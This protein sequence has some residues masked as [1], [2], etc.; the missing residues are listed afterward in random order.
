ML[1]RWSSWGAIAD[2]FDPTRRQEWSRAREDLHRLLRD[3][4]WRAASRTTLNAHF[5]DAAF[6]KAMWRAAERLGFAGGT[7]LE[8]GCG[9]GNFLAF[10]PRS[11]HLIGVEWD[12]V[13]AAIAER[14]YPSA[15]VLHESF[16][17]TRIPGSSLDL[18]VGNVPFA[19][20]VLHDPQ[21]NPGKHSIHNHF[22]IKSVAGLR[23]GGLALLLT[24]RYTLDGTSGAARTELAGMADLIGVVRLP[25][26]AHSR[27]AGTDVIT[28]LVVLRRRESGAEPQGLPWLHARPTLLPDEHDPAVQEEIAI[29]EAFLSGDPRA[30]VI[31]ELRSGHGAYQ[32]GELVIPRP[33]DVEAGVD[34]ALERITRRAVAD[35]A[36]WT[37]RRPGDGPALARPVPR[38][39][40]PVEGLVCARGAGFTRIEDGVEVEF[41]VPRSQR[42]E[43][44]WLLAMRDRLIELLDLESRPQ[45]EDLVLDEKRASLNAAYDAYVAR[46]GP[47]NRFTWLRT[48][49]QDDDGQEILRKQLAARGRIHLDTY[50]WALA[51][52]EVFDPSTQL[53]QKA[54]ILHR[55]VVAP[56][57]VP[58]RAE[59]PRD[60]LA[61]V[62]D[63]KA[64]VDLGRIAQLL[65][66]PDDE[67]ARAALGTLVYQDP[68]TDRLAPAPAY[69]S[70]N[71]RRK[72]ER[73]REAERDEPGR[74]RANLEALERVLP[75]DL[76]PQ[77][78]DARLGATWISVPVVQRFVAELLRVPLR[79]V[80]I[81]HT[82]SIWSVDAPDWSVLAT[83]E[84]GTG[85]APTSRLVRDLLEQRTTMIRVP[86]R[87][88]GGIDVEETVAAQEAAR[89]VQERFREWIWEDPDRTRD[90]VAE[91]N[92][93]FNSTVLRSY[94]GAELALP[95]LA[96]NFEPREHQVAAVARMVAEPSVL[97]AHEVGAGK[98]AEMVMGAIELRRLHLVRKPCFVVPN[99]MVEQ[100]SREFLQLYPRARVLVGDETSAGPAQRRS[101]VGR[102]SSGDWDGVIMS[103][104]VFERIPVSAA[105]QRKFVEAEVQVLRD[106]LELA[107][108]N[109]AGRSIKRME[110][111]ILNAESRIERN[112]SG[113]HD[114]DGVS[115]ERTGIDYLCVDEAHA[116]KNLRIV[117]NLEGCGQVGSR[118]ADDLL[119]KLE[120]LRSVHGHRV[121]TFATATPISNAVSEAWVVQRFLQ[122]D[123]L[124]EAGVGEFDSWAA[125]FGETRTDIEL[126]PAG[127][128]YR[129]KTRFSKYRNVPE[130][131]LQLHQVADVKMPEDLALPKPQ[132]RGGKPEVVLVT[133][134]P[135]LEGFIQSLGDRADRMTHGIVPGNDN[136]LKVC[137]D[138][139]LGALDLRLVDLVDDPDAPSKVEV[140]ADRIAAIWSRYRDAAYPDPAGL[141]PSPRRGALQ[142]V[143]ADVGTPS[144]RWNPYD[145]LRAELVARGM[146]AAGIRFVHQARNDREK[147]EL[148]AACRNGEVSVLIGS[149]E[150]MGV[151]TNV[152]LRAIALHHLDCPW[153]P[154]DVEQREGRILRQGNC[155][156]EVE[157]I[158][159]AREGSFDV[160]M[161]Q[162][163]ERKGRFV[164]Q[165]MRGRL[166][167][168]EMEDPTAS[169]LSYAEV[170]ALAAGD[171]RL[172][173][174]ARLEG[175]VGRLS[176]LEHAWSS[177]QLLLRRSAERDEIEMARMREELVVLKEAV[178]RRTS[179]KGDAFAFFLRT[180]QGE[181]IMD[182]TAA[183]K[184]I[185][186]ALSAAWMTLRL[187]G[188]EAPIELGAVG[189]FHLVG[190]AR[191][192]GEA[193]EAR[194]AL[195]L[196]NGP[197]VPGSS[198]RILADVP[199][200]GLVSRLENRVEGIETTI[201]QHRRG[202]EATATHREDVLG[203]LGKP[204]DQRDALDRA[205]A[206]LAQLRA[207]IEADSKGPS[208]ASSA[209]PQ[210]G[211]GA[212]LRQ[213]QE[214]D[215]S[216]PNYDVRPE[217]HMGPRRA[218]IR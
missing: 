20:A 187:P 71:V 111:I 200:L 118:R 74:W 198:A 34:D 206:E 91:Y 99:H 173:D 59:S 110:R 162:T 6:V 106:Q 31:G 79:R 45:V 49:R 58:T 147:G 209:A 60:A 37:Q 194:L 78:I 115:F 212:A 167:V 143:F 186:K 93:R 86:Q 163:V 36:Q 189:S 112:L 165:L 23:P 66:L 8:P 24:S 98:T 50:A 191:M 140:A 32:R 14:L 136:M 40:R 7:V 10:A 142:L 87:D 3:E 105:T 166:D 63:E 133:S 123:R 122:P 82:G 21:G 5:T 41:F 172:L 28:D 203:Q 17:Q 170:K 121:A 168:R 80:Q 135:A 95:G 114:D 102:V 52:L 125:Q 207:S 181:V 90:L 180:P 27:A 177:Q 29:N 46:F 76:G 154:A 55:R 208:D 211:P 33:P 2:V 159:Y 183:G 119:M 103:R 19:D 190:V 38:D 109:G 201:E 138:G 158:R 182:R 57:P 100:F 35:G 1:A 51:A 43:L 97:L 11:A 12:P 193:V 185:Y 155:N 153:R 25:N 18:V 89:R 68:D 15:V 96:T 113:A 9:S 65:A 196:R 61:I 215:T 132:V 39:Q 83:T 101:F 160:Y 47:I 108:N 42:D 199:P 73:A 48:G 174:L 16:A 44:R 85:R 124:R 171:G 92:R 161:W 156:P 144:D 195:R 184:A 104:S 120:Y 53:A 197:E 137:T 4:E 26:R 81:E 67:E 169:V 77:E 62:I 139:R 69:L 205:R 175:E 131:L 64:E 146:P 22:L 56:R 150:K 126:S 107:R 117:S 178:D 116:Y 214:S 192:N 94:D 210:R 70:G 130:L 13:T 72:L 75:P 88:G 54:S 164:G 127:N 157:I 179:T 84:W 202:V 30:V 218:G 141:A 151:G 216:S 149:T 145:A 204:F 128:E 176:R 213:V 217:L 148:F 134:S 129:L 152:Q 188:D